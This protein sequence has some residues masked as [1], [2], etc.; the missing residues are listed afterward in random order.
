MG[1]AMNWRASRQTGLTMV[2]LLVSMALGLIV[3][4]GATQIFMGGKRSTAV[5]EGMGTLQENGRLAMHFLQ[6]EIRMAGFP[7]NGFTAAIDAAN[8]SNGAG[9]A[10]DQLRVQNE[11]G[12]DCLGQASANPTWSHFSIGND[13]SGVPSLRCRG[14]GNAGSEQ[15]LVE[16]IEAMQI[17]YGVDTD[18][19]EFANQYLNAADVAD[20]TSVVAVRV[21]LLSAS[22]SNMAE[23]Q[24]TQT[25]QLLDGAELGPINDLQRR[26]VFV[27]TIEIRNRT[28]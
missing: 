25:Y 15:T 2:E 22:I 21:A 19:D 5:Q 11:S 26:R 20:W 6:R 12:T 14:S 27:S 18:G 17:Q 1:A 9:A 28:P 4:A 7:K 24:D 13:V 10:S 3:I 16:G 8:V 23:T